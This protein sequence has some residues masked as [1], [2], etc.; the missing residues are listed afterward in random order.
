MLATAVDIAWRA[1]ALLL[2]YLGLQRNMSLKGPCDLVTDADHASETLIV[3][4]LRQHF[5][6]HTIIAEEGS[7][8]ER[9][10]PYAWLI[11]P[12]DGTSNYAHGFPFF[13]IALALLEGRTPILAVVYDPVRDEMFTAERGRGAWRNQQPIRVS[14]TPSLADA[15]VST[16]FPYDV[17]TNSS[18]SQAFARVQARVQGVRHAGSAVLEQA[19]VAA[20]R[21]EAYWAVGL[22]PWDMAASAL[23]VA[24]AGGRVSDWH[25]DPWDPWS[26]DIIVSNGHVHEEMIQA[27]CLDD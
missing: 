3:D 13:S 21:F 8:V 18:N 26:A 23:L 6:D 7:G 24:E 2:E 1:G 12:L 4:S 11:D 27:L 5:P 9:D 17:A 15:L 19:S 20:G 22:Q 16:G 10:S 25:G 14:H